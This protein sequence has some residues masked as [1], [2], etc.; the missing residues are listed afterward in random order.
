MNLHGGMLECQ[1]LQHCHWRHM[2]VTLK[3]NNTLENISFETIQ[4]CNHLLPNKLQIVARCL[5]SNSFRYSI[6]LLDVTVI[7][8]TLMFLFKFLMKAILSET[9]AL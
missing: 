4:I 1:D 3:R 9:I 7:P 8:Y 2:S 6:S 5:G